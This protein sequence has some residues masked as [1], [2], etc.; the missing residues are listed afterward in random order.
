MKPFTDKPICPKC[1]RIASYYWNGT[2]FTVHSSCG[3]SWSMKPKD[4]KV[5][6]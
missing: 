1:G 6:A 3:Y 4:A 2:H 5:P